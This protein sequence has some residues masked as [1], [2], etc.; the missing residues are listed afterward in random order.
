[1]FSSL[2]RSIWS[3]LLLWIAAGC[4]PTV[5]Q[6]T[7]PRPPTDALR[8]RLYQKEPDKYEDL[9]LVEVPGDLIREDKS[10]ADRIGDQLKANAAAR[11]AN[12]LLLRMPKDMGLYGVGAFY[13]EKYYV[14]PFRLKPTKAVLGT[15]IYV[16]KE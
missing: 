5:L 6:P 12:G 14:F 3:A 4:G 16:V 7:A 13:Y 15:A 8:V 10:A 1:M 9:G 11:G 2:H